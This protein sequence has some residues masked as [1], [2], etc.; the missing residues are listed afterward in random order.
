LWLD[1]ALS[2]QRASGGW[3]ALWRD[4]TGSQANMALYYVLLHWWIALGDSEVVVR[5]LSVVFAVATV[6][7]VYRLTSRLFGG[8]A[9][10]TAA[11]L[12]A[13][14]SFFISYA[15]EARGYSLAILVAAIATWRFAIAVEQPSARSWTWYVVAASV[16][17]YAHFFCALVLLAHALSL[18]FVGRAR[19]P[20]RRAIAAG[21][22]I[23]VAGLPLLWFV[24][25]R[26]V[27]QIDWVPAPRAVDLYYLF[28]MFAGGGWALPALAG[29]AIVTAVALGRRWRSDDA[30]DAWRLAL[31]VCWFVIPPVV[32]Y[33]V[34]F[35]KPVFQPRYLIISLVPFVMLVAAGL[36]RLRNRT[37]FATAVALVAVLSGNSVRA[38][39]DAPDKQWWRAAVEHM[40]AQAKPGDAVGFFVYSGR[41]PFEYYARRSGLADGRVAFV[42]LASETFIAG[43]R[44]PEP[45]RE[46]LRALSAI[47][48]RVWLVRLQDGTPPGHPLRRYEQ[49]R[50]IE[51]ELDAS[52]RMVRETPFPGGIRV[53]LYELIQPH[54]PA[55]I[56][57]MTACAPGSCSPS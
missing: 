15:Q 5:A 49:G 42:D 45:S 24:A 19:L 31:V 25:F 12:L 30:P 55:P 50:V 14:N 10:V 40:A 13:L 17:L 23:G 47:H 35:A 22:A 52:Y 21:I 11:L 20:W 28:A 8:R 2:V 38:W 4:I 32:A 7:V 9:A 54:E 36:A 27:G 39:Y 57:S 6:P 3:D 29:L 33:L 37:A 44:Q 26:D 1:E 18:V 46:R 43:N 48:P 34:S 16:A 56:D 41:V 51:S 53:Q